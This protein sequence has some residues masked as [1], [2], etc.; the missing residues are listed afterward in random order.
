MCDITSS[1]TLEFN[2]ICP[3]CGSNSN[4]DGSESSLQIDINNLIESGGPVCWCG[5]VLT[6]ETHY[7][8]SG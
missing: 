4:V 7:E 8:V 6:W 2:P 3:K 1:I 5:E